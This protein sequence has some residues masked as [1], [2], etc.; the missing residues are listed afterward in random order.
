MPV[1]G[2]Q[3]SVEWMNFGSKGKI[4]I[5]GDGEIVIGRNRY[6]SRV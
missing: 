4:G 2:L 3:A 5:Y 6:R 1:L